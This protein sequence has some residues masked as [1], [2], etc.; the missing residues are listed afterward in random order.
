MPESCAKKGGCNVGKM[1]IKAEILIPLFVSK[2]VVSLVENLF[3]LS[4]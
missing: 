3:F 2:T 4:V 1:E